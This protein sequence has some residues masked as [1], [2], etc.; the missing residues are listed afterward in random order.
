M[1]LLLPTALSVASEHWVEESSEVMI[2]LLRLSVNFDR[3]TAVIPTCTHT[4]TQLGT[5]C[6]TTSAH[7]R[8]TS[9]SDRVWKPGFSPDTS[10]SSALETFVIIALYKSTFTIP[11]EWR[12]WWQN[13]L[14]KRHGLSWQVCFSAPQICSHNFWCYIN[15]VCVCMKVIFSWH[16]NQTFN[17]ST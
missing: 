10:V 4:H 15:F 7:S 1:P 14:I 8:T 12:C 6:Q 11:T 17:R 13:E 9:P 3:L 5:L 2:E 16:N